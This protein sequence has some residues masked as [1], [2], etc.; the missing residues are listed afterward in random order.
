MIGAGTST[1]VKLR[2]G[3]SAGMR[4]IMSNVNLTLR[5]NMPEVR[6]RQ[7]CFLS[8]LSTIVDLK[9]VL[10]YLSEGVERHIPEIDLARALNGLLLA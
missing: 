3:Y 4:R 8:K 2:F 10:A 1:Y 5:F 6:D 7:R 9:T